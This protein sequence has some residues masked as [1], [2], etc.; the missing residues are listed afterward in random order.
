MAIRTGSLLLISFMFIS[1]YYVNPITI[2]TRVT[3]QLAELL[4]Q[5]SYWTI[6]MYKYCHNVTCKVRLSK[7]RLLRGDVAPLLHHRFLH[8]P[9]VGPG[10][11]AHFLGN[12]HAL[13][14]RLQLGNQLGDVLAGP[15]WLQGTLLLG[16]VL[17]YGLRL[18]EA[19]LPPFLEATASRSTQ[20]P[21][22][23]GTTS[24]RS[25][26]LHILLGDL[27]HFLGPLGAVSGGG[28]AGGVILTLLFHHG[29]TSYNV[30]LY[31][32]N[33][34]FGPTL[35]LVLSPTDLWSLDVAVLD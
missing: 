6:I 10:P 7:T 4:H 21:G 31:V 9:G 33:L 22:F 14:F 11:G 28:V 12:I 35:R 30:I 34:L 27:A 3:R 18:V 8:L 25:V 19:F 20:L 29:L 1:P 32:M 24:D 26:L 23:L 17:H 5:N 16:G 2:T 15:L 13:L